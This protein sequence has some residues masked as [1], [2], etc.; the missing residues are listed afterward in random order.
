MTIAIVQC[1]DS[2]NAK[3]L[4]GWACVF[5]LAPITSSDVMRAEYLGDAGAGGSP[6]PASYGVPTDGPFGP[7]VPVLVQ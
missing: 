4:L 3:K 1:K 6:C 5:A 7:K 2:A